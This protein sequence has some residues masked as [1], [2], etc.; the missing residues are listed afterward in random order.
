MHY[1]PLDNNYVIKI[2]KKEETTKGGVI[3]PDEVREAR[4]VVKEYGEV[5]AVGN[6]KLLKN[7]QRGEMSVHVGET[8]LF[9]HY[10]SNEVKLEEGIFIINENEIVGVVDVPY[11]EE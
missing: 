4:G 8:V 7:G 10:P 11:R 9:F 3:I 5:I 1:K 2:Q 6:G